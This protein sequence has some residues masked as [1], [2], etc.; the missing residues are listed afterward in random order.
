MPVGFP[1]HVQQLLDEYR[2][3]EW[4]GF[5]ALLVP[6]LLEPFG[7]ALVSAMRLTRGDELLD[8]GCGTGAMIRLAVATGVEPVHID[9]VDIDQGAV[10]V[11]RRHCPPAARL[12]VTDGRRLPYDDARFDAVICHQTLQHVED[13]ASTLTE[14]HRVLRPGGRL[15]VACWGPLEQQ[16]PFWT[17]R[18]A[19]SGVDSPLSETC[20]GG[21]TS[22][23]SRAELE[24]RIVDAGFRDVSVEAIE[25][26]VLF[27]DAGV[28]IAAYAAQSSVV[29]DALRELSPKRQAQLVED[30]STRLASSTT[31]AGVTMRMVSHVA[32]AARP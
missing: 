21:A 13:K 22:L 29:Q 26:D 9:G 11:A 8:V 25:R 31:D 4:D 20:F 32:T 27:A 24:E 17:L 16:V 5:E 30:L 12:R 3:R 23:S 2:G 28:F 18:L 15:G 19:L 1:S 6:P 10:D 14:M 7:A